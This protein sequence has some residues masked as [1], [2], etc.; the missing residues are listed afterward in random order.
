MDMALVTKC[1]ITAKEEQGNAVFAYSKRCLTELYI[2][3]KVEGFSFKS[4]CTMWIIKED[5]PIALQ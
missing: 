1:I 4:G 2:T 5:W 3:N